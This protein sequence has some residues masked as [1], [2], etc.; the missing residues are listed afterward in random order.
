MAGT[1]T[2]D[3]VDG[4]VNYV[5]EIKPYH[6][7]IV[8]TLIEY[9]YT[10]CIEVTLTEEFYL[11]LG[12]PS[13]PEKWGWTFEEAASYFNCLHVPLDDKYPVTGVDFLLNRFF[14]NTDN[15]DK[16]I[17]GTVLNFQDPSGAGNAEYTVDSSFPSV[18]DAFEIKTVDVVSL[19]G[20][21]FT[22]STTTNNYLIWFNTTGT[23]PLPVVPGFIPREVAAH[24]FFG[25]PY[26]DRF[27]LANAL[28]DTLEAIS[29]IYVHKEGD[30]VVVT[31]QVVGPVLAP[32]VDNG[33]G[34]TY[35]QVDVGSE[36]G[37]I[38]QETID[39]LHSGTGIA[40]PRCYAE[41]PDF[42]IRTLRSGLVF[43]PP[44]YVEK[45]NSGGDVLPTGSP[46]T[47]DPG[48]YINQLCGAFGLIY[49]HY[50]AWS[51][52]EEY[53]DDEYVEYEGNIYQLIIGGPTPNVGVVPTN[54]L[55][56]NLLG[57]GH[58]FP[59]PLLESIAGGTPIG[60]P[61]GSPPMPAPLSASGFV[62]SNT[63]NVPEVPAVS[64]WQDA[65]LPGMKFEITG[66]VFDNRI[67]TVLT[68]IVSGTDLI[69]YTREPVST[70]T[71]NLGQFQIVRFG[72]DEPTECIT[73]NPLANRGLEQK[74]QTFIFDTIDLQWECDFWQYGVI[75]TTATFNPNNGQMFDYILH[76]F[77]D[78]RFTVFT[79]DVIKI[80]GNDN[81]GFYRVVIIDYDG[82]FSTIRVQATVP[83]MIGT[84]WV[85]A[86][87]PGYECDV[88][89]SINCVNGEDDYCGLVPPLPAMLPDNCG[90]SPECTI[91]AGIPILNCDGGSPVSCGTI[92]EPCL[93]AFETWDSCA[94]DI[95]IWN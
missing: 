55:Y 18:N 4:L 54:A 86:L 64:T 77:G 73:Q 26:T 10:D 66:T 35:T 61:T 91:T 6:T 12:M 93:D 53:I 42:D 51:P 82:T 32:I 75:K 1:T 20:T 85:E 37:V 27:N 17:N 33:T 30:E 84:G 41:H 59:I 23:D 52:T 50:D 11:D 68:T 89:P 28:Y 48:D 83:Y 2:I 95:Q 15:F 8:E 36:A 57:R 63:L 9:I 56:W 67:F 79:N 19:L 5:L 34:F 49:Q 45:F 62:I 16:L 94:W 22:F 29:D 78:I 60:P 71:M 70:N 31:G 3:P 7:K 72:Y 21:Y 47:I 88:G 39:P 13:H 65:L 38:V 14:L 58:T 87:E 74:A 76:V 24:D 69:V 92:P 46:A 43:P 90:G 25:N 40:V 44:L 80:V 81:T